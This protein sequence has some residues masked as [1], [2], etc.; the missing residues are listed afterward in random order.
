MPRKKN[1]WGQAANTGFKK[2]SHR[3]DVGAKRSA[4]GSYPSDRTFGS[5]VQRSVIEQF[6]IDSDWSRWRKGLE[7]YYQ[8]A[9]YRLNELDKDPSSSTFDEYI[10]SIYTA[11]LYQGTDQEFNVRFDGYKFATQNSDTNAHYVLKR[12]PINPPALGTVTGVR[13]D[14]AAYPINFANKE[15]WVSVNTT[16]DTPL[17]TS[18]SGDRVTDGETE[19]TLKRV[20]TSDGHPAL[21]KGNSKETKVFVEVPLAELQNNPFVQTNNNQI[22]SLV[23]KIGYLDGLYTRR[24]IGTEEFIDA[25]NTFSVK[26]DSTEA[27]Q[28]FQILDQNELPATLYDIAGLT[29]LYTT[30]N[31]VPKVQG[32]YEFDKAEYQSLFGSQYLTAQLVGSEASQLSFA[33]LPFE[34]RSILDQGDGTALI[35]AEI[36]PGELKLYA[37]ADNGFLVFTDFSFT[38]LVRD[39]YNGQYYHTQTPGG[40]DWMRV[41]TDIDPWMDEI[42]ASG[43]NIVPATIYSCSCPS[44]ASAQ[45]AMPEPTQDAGTRANNRQRRYPLPSAKSKAQL[46][47]GRSAGKVQSWENERR[48]TSFKQCKHTIAAKFIEKIKTQEPKSY[49]SSDAR[50]A[51]ETK[52]S[53]E[54]QSVGQEFTQSYKRGEM[55]INELILAMSL[56]LNL[57]EIELAYALLNG[58]IQ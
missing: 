10:D 31:A 43:G 2:I 17:L 25:V 49:P 7:F 22:S 46:D 3:T 34:I 44:Y 13:A 39:A 29:A 15:I 37:N 1:G 14:R 53:A 47:G 18:M 9:W 24:S 32:T 23:G 26:I 42:F 19:A 16:A 50:E 56:G 5:V 6:N 55:S 57:D 20:L 52:L 41:E 27:A 11:K 4:S 30:T 45:L 38:K 51:F 48:R 12:T 33:I 36:F 35:E 21:Y 54:I 58:Q 28:S 8:M 40:T